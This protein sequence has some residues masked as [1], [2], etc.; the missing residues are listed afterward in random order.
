MWWVLKKKQTENW[1][2]LKED[3]AE[4]NMETSSQKNKQKEI[5]LRKS[6]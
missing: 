4:K 3:D 1:K 2:Q 6:D 5:T